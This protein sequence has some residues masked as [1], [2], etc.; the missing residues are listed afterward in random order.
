MRAATAT[1]HPRTV[2][3]PAATAGTCTAVS[4]VMGRDVAADDAAAATSDTA[5][6]PTF[7]EDRGSA[8]KA[9]LSWHYAACGRPVS[10]TTPAGSAIPLGQRF[11]VT[12]SRAL[13]RRHFTVPRRRRQAPE[14]SYAPGP[15]A[16]AG[17]AGIA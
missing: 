7:R 17:C 11:G 10:C 8:R 4:Q 6:T 16:S 2:A 1:G 12:R 13:V 15:A 14:R 3:T 9:T 5:S